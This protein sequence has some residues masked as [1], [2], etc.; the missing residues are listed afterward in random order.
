MATNPNVPHEPT[1]RNSDA[2]INY[3]AAGENVWLGEDFWKRFHEDQKTE[4]IGIAKLLKSQGPYYTD[5]DFAIKAVEAGLSI[6]AHR[7]YEKDKN[8]A[9]LIGSLRN[10]NERLRS[11]VQKLQ[12]QVKDVPD[13]ATLRDKIEA[14]NDKAFADAF[15]YVDDFDYG[16]KTCRD[17]VAQNEALDAM[18]QIAANKQDGRAKANKIQDFGGA[19]GNL[20][21]KGALQQFNDS[22]PPLTEAEREKMAIDHVREL[23]RLGLIGDDK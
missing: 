13:Y 1:P 10:E 20:I 2:P 12:A 22:I 9:S 17:Y 19:I 5:V 7:Y 11:Q 23:K 16:V 15:G 3:N 6:A 8:E 14:E 21:G 18:K 4:I